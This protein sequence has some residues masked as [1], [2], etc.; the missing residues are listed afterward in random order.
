M[1]FRNPFDNLLLQVL[2]MTMSPFNQPVLQ[3]DSYVT[4]EFMNEWRLVSHRVQRP[5]LL[6]SPDS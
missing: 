1:T 2:T 6:P 4:L 3:Q 5:S